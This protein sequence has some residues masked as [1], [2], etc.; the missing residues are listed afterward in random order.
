MNSF[1]AVVYVLLALAVVTGFNSGFLRSV[2]TILGYVCAMPVAVK[3]TPLL[4]PALAGQSAAPWAQGSIAFFAIFLAAGIVLGA[5]MRYAVS[6]VVGPSA[7]LLDRLA[8]ALF[9]AIRIGLV[10]V[11]VVL[12]FD[13]LIPADREPAFLTGSRLRPL[14]SLAGQYGL[15][16]LPPD[17][18]A[19][20]DQVK[21]ERRL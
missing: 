4:S 17:A 15:K 3:A 14:L 6:A 12:V 18:A 1:D 11:A 5:L 21:R 16:S 19:F 2:A 9:G 7:G 20:I 10:A 13:R 8:G